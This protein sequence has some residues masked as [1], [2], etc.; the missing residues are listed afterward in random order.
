[1]PGRLSTQLEAA[2]FRSAAPLDRE[3]EAMYVL[4]RGTGEVDLLVASGEPE[5]SVIAEATRTLLFGVRAPVAKL[6]HLVLMY[7]YS[8]QPRHQGNLARI[9]TETKVDLSEVERYLADVHP[10]MLH[11]LRARV[12]AARHPPPAPPRPTRRRRQTL[13]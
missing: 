6:E 4:A 13:V 9:V 1:M 12:E 8:N 2:G 7:L 10:E 3:R 5:S 11:A